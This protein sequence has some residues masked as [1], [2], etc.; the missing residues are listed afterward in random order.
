MQAERYNAIWVQSICPANSRKERSAIKRWF[1]VLALHFRAVS[2]QVRNPR[3]AS[4]S[5]REKVNFVAVTSLLILH[6]R[7]KKVQRLF[8]G[9]GS[10]FR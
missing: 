8:V 5:I 3:M 1:L 7:N 2:S 6:I 10:Y 9:D 4:R